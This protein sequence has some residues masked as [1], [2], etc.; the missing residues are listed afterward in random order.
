MKANVDKH[1][2][3]FPFQADEKFAFWALNLLQRREAMQN[4]SIYFDNN[5]HKYNSVDQ[6]KKK[7]AEDS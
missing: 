2:L 3:N 5:K 6:L 7:L 4:S 1:M